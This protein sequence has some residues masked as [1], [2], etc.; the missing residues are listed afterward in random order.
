MILVISLVP[1][2]FL[3]EYF[4]SGMNSNLVIELNQQQ[5]A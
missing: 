4:S 3:V 1:N 2:N 5:A